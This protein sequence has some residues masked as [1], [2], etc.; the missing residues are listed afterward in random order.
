MLFNKN[1]ISEKELLFDFLEKAYKLKNFDYNNISFKNFIKDFKKSLKEF[2]DFNQPIEY[3]CNND[4]LKWHSIKIHI[5]ITFFNLEINKK[6]RVNLENIRTGLKI[7]QEKK[8]FKNEEIIRNKYKLQSVVYLI[9]NPFYYSHEDDS[10][11]FFCNSLLSK[12]NNIDDLKKKYKNI[13]DNKLEYENEIYDNIQDIC[14]ENLP[15]KK[16]SKEEKYNFDYLL[17]YIN[18]Y[19][20]F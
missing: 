7:V 15:N 13:D 12:T 8:L 10:L 1:K 14:I 20:K 4:E 2:P 9:I 17:K 6:N 19:V 11:I 16:Y 3:D 18:F 5:F